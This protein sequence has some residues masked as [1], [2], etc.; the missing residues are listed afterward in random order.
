MDATCWPQWPLCMQAVVGVLEISLQYDIPSLPAG[1]PKTAAV[2][3]SMAVLPEVQRQ[4]I[5][6]AM[7]EAAQQWAASQGAHSMALFVFRDNY[8]A[9]RCDSLSC[10]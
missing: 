6:T 10:L 3:T 4:G 9:I 8:A 5:G 1:Q 7:L 2:V